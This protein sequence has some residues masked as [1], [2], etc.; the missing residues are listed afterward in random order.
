MLLRHRNGC[1][2]ARR[3]VRRQWPPTPVQAPSGTINLYHVSAICRYRMIRY[4][5]IFLGLILFPANASAKDGQPMQYT[6]FTSRPSSLDT[7]ES[8]RHP[9]LGGFESSHT[10]FTATHHDVIQVA[11]YDKEMNQTSRFDIKTLPGMN[12]ARLPALLPNSMQREKLTSIIPSDLQ[13]RR[14]VILFEGGLIFPSYLPPKAKPIGSREWR[15]ELRWYHVYGNY[16]FVTVNRGPEIVAMEALMTSSKG[17][18]LI[19][20]LG[21]SFENPSDCVFGSSW[22]GM[23]VWIAPTSC[24]GDPD[25]VTLIQVQEEALPEDFPKDLVR[26]IR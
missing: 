25:S 1:R 10:I 12:I 26:W 14:D 22:G 15:Y 19:P 2:I 20:I 13:G 3:F 24:P 16:Y 8:L 5:A 21:E 23:T 11:A 6:V 18:D 4:I 7:A 9:I 17:E